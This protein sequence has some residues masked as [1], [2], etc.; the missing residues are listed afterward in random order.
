MT[1]LVA[2]Q[3]VH[4]YF[5]FVGYILIVLFIVFIQFSCYIFR[6]LAL[7]IDI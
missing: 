7:T 6:V 1:I 3:K 5:D 4:C 2:K